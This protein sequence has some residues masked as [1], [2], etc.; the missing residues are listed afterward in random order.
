MIISTKIRYGLR[1]LL[2]IAKANPGEGVLQKDI[3]ERQDI[4]NKYLDHIIRDMK[5]ANIICNQKLKKSGYKLNIPASEIT[6]YSIYQ[7]FEDELCLV[8]C[9]DCKN[10]KRIDECLALPV[11]K[12]LNSRMIDFMKSITLQDIVDGKNLSLIKVR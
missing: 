2:E 8:E 3:S 10:C 12:E 1:A 9:I 6:V 7:A 11:W 5:A 4:S